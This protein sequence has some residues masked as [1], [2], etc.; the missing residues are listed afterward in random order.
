MRLRTI[1]LVALVAVLAFVPQAFA[2]S[3][4]GHGHGGGSSASFNGTSF[5]G[6][7][8]A[9]STGSAGGGGTLS[10][11]EPFATLLVGLGLLG[12]RFLRRK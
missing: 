5:S 6:S 7:S 2:F 3:S 9:A 4:G 8:G 12:A 1:T 11:P 10:T